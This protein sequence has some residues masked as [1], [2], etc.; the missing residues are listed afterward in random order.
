MDTHP[1]AGVDLPWLARRIGT[2]FYLYDAGRLYS[3]ITAIRALTTVP[4]VQARYAMKAC[5]ARRVL[6][7]MR[8]HGIWIDAVSGNEVLRALTAG[9]PSHPDQPE[10]MLTTDVFRDNALDVVC[11]YGVLPNLGSPHMVQELIQA[12][13]SGPIALRLNPGFGHGHI[14]SC[15][16]G[17]P[18]SKHG[19]W[20][21]EVPTV[22]ERA[23]R[24][25]LPTVLL[26]A[27]V[28]SGPT[29]GEFLANMQRLVDVFATQLND[30]PDLQA[31]NLGGGLPYPYDPDGAEVDLQAF[32]SLLHQAQAR[33]SRQ[34]GRDIR[35]EIEPGRFFVAAAGFLITRVTDIKRTK[36]NERGPGH[37]FVLVDAGFCDLIRPA[38][39]GSFHHISVEDTNRDGRCE[40]VV[41]AGPLCESG[42]VFTRDNEE[43]LRPRL[44]PPVQIGDLI[45]IHDA[46][47]YG[48][49]MSSNYNSIGRAPQVWWQDGQAYL[50]SRRETFEDLRR[51]EC[52]TA[53]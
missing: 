23:A 37:T 39:Y 40:P 36:S 13:Y 11:T 3:R 53:L 17:G 9:Y 1:L 22:A 50:L 47:A 42:D 49:T 5:S 4:G 10:I 19:I 44:L 18:S 2:P 52:F 46:G 35:V 24:Q 12:G 48:S 21:D 51:T 14:Q 29:P 34:T 43:F 38:M 32:G 8:E 16:T 30:F 20:I 33:F 28:G 31:V 6:E 45:V 27:H 25:G 26:H 15:D 7:A 41:I